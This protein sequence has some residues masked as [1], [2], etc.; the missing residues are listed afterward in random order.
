[1]NYKAVLGILGKTMLIEAILLVCPLL[2][3]IIYG[4]N[5]Y[6]DFLLPIVGLMFIGY[7]LARLKT[8]DKSIYAKEGFVIVALVW[9]ILS[10]VG[11][12]PFVLS[13]AI[14]SYIDAVFETVS[15]FTTTGASI[16]SDVEALPQSLLFW[17]S[18]THFV[19][20]MGILVFALA[21]LPKYDSG[22]MHVFR[23]ESPGPSASK[24]V[25]KLTFTA[26]ILYGIYIVM[27]L[28]EMILLLIGRMPLF[29]SI[30]HAFG[31]AGTGGFSIKN[32]S[33]AYYN[34]TY[35][36][37]VIAVFMFLFGINFNIFY[38][39]LIGNLKKI[40][41]SE[42]LRTYFIIVLVAT[43]AI[44]LNILSLTANFGQAI[45]YSFFQVASIGSSTGYVTADFDQWPALSKSI[46][47]VLMIVGAC[48]GSTGGGIKVSRLVMLVKSAF[49]D[50]KRLIHPRA[51]VPVKFEGE[52][53][54]KNTER[55][56]HTYFS[57]WIIIVAITTVLLCLDINDF[58]TNF[59]A[60]L[61]CIGNI[62][63]GLSNAGIGLVGPTFNFSGYSPCAKVL[64]SFVMLFG[65]L[66]IFP[67]LILF[68]PRTW[69]RG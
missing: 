6:L 4:E 12:V 24:L 46:I 54:D 14:P 17:R 45:R 57:L 67:M 60:T 38:L 10:L 20:G 22:V 69:K 63:P 65:R 42:E 43:L 52:L 53:L 35:I 50:I 16:L 68:I 41:K 56:V 58:F 30:V 44:A 27:T 66:E 15:G 48:G 11:A 40:L 55:N 23:A 61:S 26:R 33:I 25:S 49:A 21:F 39:V 28:V 34:S 62:G 32:S 31:T 19:G 8:K 59:T 9:I 18:F 47:V 2:V 37:M 3:G 5:T 29:D 64:L 51:I 36:E 7:P 1:M 13:G